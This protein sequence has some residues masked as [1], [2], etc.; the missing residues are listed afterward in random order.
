MRPGIY[1][2]KKRES[3]EYLKYRTFGDNVRSLIDSFFVDDIN[4]ATCF[5][6]DAA[7]KAREKLVRIF[8]FTTFDIVTF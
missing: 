1:F 7:E 4:L 2:I 3:E 8:P 6:W 5:T